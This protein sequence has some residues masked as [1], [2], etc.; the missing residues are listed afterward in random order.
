M[1]SEDGLGLL[2]GQVAALTAALVALARTPE[3]KA[4][5][6]AAVEVLARQPD[7]PAATRKGVDSVLG[8]LRRA[9]TITETDA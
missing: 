6:L 2:A 3:D 1:A 7:L 8:T 5:A 9:P 4:L